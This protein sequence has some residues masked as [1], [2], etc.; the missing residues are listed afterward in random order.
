[1]AIER[2]NSL[3]CRVLILFIL[4]FSAAADDNTFAILSSSGNP[5]LSNIHQIIIEGITQ[6]TPQFDHKS[7]VINQNEATIKQGLLTNP[8]FAVVAIGSEAIALA[9]SI[10]ITVPLITAATLSTDQDGRAGVSL[11][12]A[13]EQLK[14]K[15]RFYLPH[16]RKIHIGDEG[17]QLIW[18]TADIGSPEF[19]RQKI[20]NDQKSMVKY[21]WDTINRVDPKTEAVWIN[22][23]IE[24]IYLYK[25]SELAWER[26][27]TLISNNVNHLESGSLLA[28]YPDFKGMGKRLADLLSLISLSHQDPSQLEPLSA[29]HQGINLRTAQ[30]LGIQIPP[31]IKR[32]FGVVIK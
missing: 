5:A 19:V 11:S 4:S 21:L 1:M 25:L 3:L 24:H 28:F 12:L 22:T 8:P 32:H 20:N 29:I 30:H 10:P 16:I 27:V 9:Q 26:N 13:A 31:G 23:N 14:K 18:F 2:F 6:N 15:I 17:G 7:F